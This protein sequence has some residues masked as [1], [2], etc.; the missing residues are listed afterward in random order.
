MINGQTFE[1][2]FGY[3]S[4][5]E[6]LFEVSAQYDS[7]R[8][9]LQIF[10]VYNLEKACYEYEDE[11]PVYVEKNFRAEIIKKLKQNKR[12]TDLEFNN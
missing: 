12:F 4:E 11:W 10:Y 3:G 8:K 2:I 9:E 6:E 5:T 1:M 7:Y